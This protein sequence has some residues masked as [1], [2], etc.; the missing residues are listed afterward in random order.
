MHEHSL[1]KNL[2]RQADAIRRQHDAMRVDEIRVEIGPLSGVEPLLLASAFKQLACDETF[3]NAQLIIDQVE[4]L[5][6]CNACDKQFVIH[7]FDFRCADCGRGLDVIRGDELQLVS[8]S[9]A[10]DEPATT[11]KTR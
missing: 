5:A 3:C 4:L 8:V 6:R 10:S 2:L 7:E 9:L 1:V 11:G